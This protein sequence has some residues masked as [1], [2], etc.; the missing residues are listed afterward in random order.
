[1][2]ENLAADSWVLDKNYLSDLN[3]MMTPDQ[4]VGERY[5]PAQQADIDT[6]E[7]TERQEIGRYFSWQVFIEYRYCFQPAL[8]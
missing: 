1:M 6:E 5:S 3:S 8:S 7:F 4:V 2:R